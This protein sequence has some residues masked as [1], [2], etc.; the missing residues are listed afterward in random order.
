MRA[1]KIAV[2]VGGLALLLA[3]CARPPTIEPQ[4]LTGVPT[5]APQGGGRYGSDTSTQPP[6]TGA[7]APPATLAEATS[8]GAGNDYGYGS[9][10]G[11]TQATPSAAQAALEV[12][13]SPLGRI[14]VDGQ[15][16]TLYSLTGD[17]ATRSTC[18][19]GCAQ[20]WPPFADAGSITAGAGVDSA[21]MGTLQREDGMVQHTY[22]GHPLY[23][24]SGDRGP[25][26]TNG[27]GLGGVWFVLSPDGEI[28]R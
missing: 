27:Q 21:R 16:F 6:A 20:T 28:V 26:D 19:G 15:G 22:N 14:L 8:T 13:D 24:Y 4:P 25:G 1:R 3:S 10:V 11:A 9:G 7:P 5:T 23:H 18:S 12:A 17:S 2:L